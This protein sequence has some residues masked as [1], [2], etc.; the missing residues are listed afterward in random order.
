MASKFPPL[1]RRITSEEYEE[2]LRIAVEEGLKRFD[3]MG[4]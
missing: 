2:G 4:L 3:G 1:D